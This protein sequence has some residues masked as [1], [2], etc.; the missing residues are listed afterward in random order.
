MVAIEHILTLKL[1]GFEI[2]IEPMKPYSHYSQ[3]LE[4]MLNPKDV[5]YSLADTNNYMWQN[6]IYSKEYKHYFIDNKKVLLSDELK[7]LFKMEVETID[8]RK[9]VYG[10]LLGE[11]ELRRF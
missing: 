9:I 8:Q 7:K 11:D 3:H 10:L 2:D 4:F 1:L 5:D 6:F